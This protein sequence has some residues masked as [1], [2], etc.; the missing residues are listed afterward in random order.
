MHLPAAPAEVLAPYTTW[1]A[2]IIKMGREHSRKMFG[3][4]P[5]KIV[6]PDTP[7]QIQWLIQNDGDWAVSVFH[8]WVPL[9]TITLRCQPVVDL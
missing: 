5:D 9:L 8:F 3:K 6:A 1:V 7:L 2:R 4:D